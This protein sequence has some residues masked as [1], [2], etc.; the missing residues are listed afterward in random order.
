M[1]T[2]KIDIHT[3]IIPKDLPD[4][5]AKFGYG[6]WVRLDHVSSDS[7]NMMKNDKFFRAVEC[8]CWDPRKR[9][10]ECD[11]TSVN[12]QV[13]ST[14]PVLFSYWAKP[15]DTFWLS[16]ILND[17][18]A[19]IVDMYPLR[20]IGLGTLPM[21]DKTLAV[22]ELER[23]MN[24]LNF[25]GIQIGS[26]INGKNLND[27]DFLPI[28]EAASDLGSSIFV[29]PWDIMGK[30]QMNKYWLPWLVGM[31]A[32]TSRAICSLLFGG[33]FEKFP[34][35]RFAFAHGGGSFLATI[36]RIQHGFRVRPDLCAIDNNRDPIDYLNKFWVDS[37]VHDF[38]S[39]TYLIKKVGDE[40]IVLGSDYP[41]PL[42]EAIPGELI[43]Q[44][45]LPNQTKENLLFKNA[46]DWLNLPYDYFK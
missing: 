3:H 5:K 35:L 36:G 41:F 29:H 21:Q 31:P 42:G 30:E 39:L 24:E 10:D 20:F 15:S 34:N 17:H 1:I 6:E 37:L 40:K 46:L 33:I 43:E 22:K 2:L 8:N 19:D 9:L 23:C 14:I 44:S 7:A 32:E 45:K 16:K 27:A 13:L 28:F 38:D 11:Q 4:L 18:I 25:K 12:V 26:N